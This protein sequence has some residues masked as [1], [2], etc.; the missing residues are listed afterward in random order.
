MTIC[1]AVRIQTVHQPLH[2]NYQMQPAQPYQMQPAQPIP[3][4]AYGAPGQQAYPPPPPGQQP[5]P[6]AYNND[7]AYPPAAAVYPPLKPVNS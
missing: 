5:P 2:N 4:P 1:V 6:P 7:P 3:P